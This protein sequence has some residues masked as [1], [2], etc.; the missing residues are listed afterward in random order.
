MQDRGRLGHQPGSW[1]A[2]FCSV[3]LV[4][5]CFTWFQGSGLD[6]VRALSPTI[7]PCCLGMRGLVGLLPNAQPVEFTKNQLPISCRLLDEIHWAPY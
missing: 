1:A 6:L 3:R 7:N 4:D 2:V 5:D